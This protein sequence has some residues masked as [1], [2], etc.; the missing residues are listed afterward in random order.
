V[1]WSDALVV[2]LF[3]VVFP[4]IAVGGLLMFRNASAVGDWGASVSRPKPEDHPTFVAKPS[5][6]D[7]DR[8]DQ[9][10]RTSSARFMGVALMVIG[11]G[12]LLMLLVHALA[13]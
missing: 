3:W 12:G 7:W 2:V 5:L 13:R 9:E 4:L 10:I 1:D 11:L 6:L 8:W